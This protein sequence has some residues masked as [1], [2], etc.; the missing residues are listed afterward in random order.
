MML[1][2]VFVCCFL[3]LGAVSAVRNI[4]DFGAIAGDSSIE[5][6]LTNGKALLAAISAANTSDDRTVLIPVG[7]VY[8]YVPVNNFQSVSQVTLQVDGTLSA[9]ATNISLW[10]NDSDGTALNMLDFEDCEQV[11]ITGSGSILGNGYN[12]WVYTIVKR[13][14]NRPHMIHFNRCTQ[15]YVAGVRL[16]NS[17]QYHLLLDDVA[18]V[19]VEGVDIHVDVTAQR[20]LLHEHG[21]LSAATGLPTFPLNTD[22]IDPSGRDIIIRNVTIENFDDAV[23]VKPSNGGRKFS[24][25][26]NILVENSRVKFSVGMTIGSV[27][28]NDNVNCVRNVTFRNVAMLDPIKAIYIKTNPGNSGTGIIANITYENFTIT[29]AIWWAIYIGPQQQKQPD[30]G[31]PGC[32]LYPLVKNCPTQ[33][34]VP[35]YNITLRNIAIDGTLLSPGI[36][37][38]NETAPCSGF[39]FDNVIVSKPG[40]FPIGA[41]YICENIEG[42][43]LNS[44]PTPP[45]F[46]SHAARSRGK[47]GLRIRRAD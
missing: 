8:S 42:V 1:S 26:E 24:C 32:M 45:C 34:R 44:S 6:S 43:S 30:G 21:L 20:A 12:W 35:M 16:L 23:A 19:I 11:S 4:D 41:T 13:K 22:G 27:P 2:S 36:L 37:R 3:L 31:G 38:C 9:F 14:D 5:A 46:G 28:P 15:L 17:A 33:P 18:S 10:P 29:N 39:V 40:K 25:S 7:K 47:K